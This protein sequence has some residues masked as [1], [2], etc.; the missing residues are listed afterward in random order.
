MFRRYESYHRQNHWQNHRHDN[1]IAYCL[2]QDSGQ[3]HK[4]LRLTWLH[5]CTKFAKNKFILS[6]CTFF[7][8]ISFKTQRMQQQ[9]RI[10][11]ICEC[12]HPLKVSRHQQTNNL[13]D[14]TF[15][16]TLT[17]LRYQQKTVNQCHW[18]S[19]TEDMNEIRQLYRF[20]VLTATLA[21]LMSPVVWS[22]REL[23]MSR[24][25]W[26][27]FSLLPPMSIICSCSLPH[28]EFN[29]F[30]EEH[31]PTRGRFSLLLPWQ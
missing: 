19:G 5:T 1:W 6:I 21:L 14:E 18:W 30:R 7:T 31:I 2:R 16:I 27:T 28:T 3:R 22:M 11:D 10:F 8:K 17:R 9:R 12:S 25:D 23:I 20:A 24:R 29:C 15:N 13:V 26:T 4:M